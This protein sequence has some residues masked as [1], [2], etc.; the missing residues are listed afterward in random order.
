MGGPRA[1]GDLSL[2]HLTQVWLAIATDVAAS[3]GYFFHRRA[4]Q[5]SGAA[6]DT[7]RQDAL[8]AACERLTGI[9]LPK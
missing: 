9:S 8:I 7:H 4:K 3:G 5:A 6:R 1:T 2:G